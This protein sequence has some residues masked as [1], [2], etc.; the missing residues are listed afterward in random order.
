MTDFIGK[1]R[2][3]AVVMTVCALL[4]SC[5]GLGGEKQAEELLEVSVSPDVA[6]YEAGY[7]F[8]DVKCSGS[9]TLSLTFDE[10]AEEWAS[11]GPAG[12]TSGTGSGK[13][14][15]LSWKENKSSESRVCYIVLESGE[16]TA[17]AEFTQLA[18]GENAPSGTPGVSDSKVDV[19][20]MDWMELPAMDD[21]SLEY[22]AHKFKHDGSWYRNYSFAYSRKDV[23]SLWVAYPLCKFYTSGT[24]GR[25]NA[26]AYDPLLGTA[27]SPAPFSGYGG[28]KDR[29]HLLPSDSRQMVGKGNFSDANRQ[30]YYGTNMAPQIGHGFNQDIWA[31]LEQKINRLSSGVDTMYVVTGCVL[32]DSPGTT[33]DSDGK[34]ITIPSAFFKAC[35]AYSRSSTFNTWLSAGYLLEHKKYNSNA[36]TPDMT[37]TIEELERR[38]GITFFA[39]LASKVGASEAAKIKK[40]NPDA[41]GF[42]N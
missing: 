7:R 41:V 39:N 13:T 11:I 42:W 23:I 25:S 15:Y 10:S 14:A 4:L 20:R 17:V 18:S 2:V 16:D 26:W 32:T 5:S 19:T 30:T 3:A 22:F 24:E 21:A 38:T 34:K 1:Y 8:I 28:D 37:L 12:Q 35:L 9:W 31:A 27:D 6:G 33:K 29:G 36:I 40:Q